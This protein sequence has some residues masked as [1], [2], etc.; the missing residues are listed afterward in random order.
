MSSGFTNGQVFQQTSETEDI[1]K[2]EMSFLAVESLVILGL[3]DNPTKLR[4][5]VCRD[6]Y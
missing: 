4:I 5:N 2:K 6:A 3:P 1:Q